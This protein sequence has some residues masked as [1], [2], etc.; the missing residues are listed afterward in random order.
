MA[1]KTACLC[2][3]ALLVICVSATLILALYSPDPPTEMQTRVLN[4]LLGIVPVGAYALF[5]FIQ[6]A[7]RK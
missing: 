1:D 6:S 2:S 3:F 5:T 7:R 4:S